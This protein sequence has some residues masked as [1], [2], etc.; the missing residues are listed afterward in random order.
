ME[1]ISAYNATYFKLKYKNKR[2]FIIPIRNNDIINNDIEIIN[3]KILGA[4]IIDDEIFNQL[5]TFIDENT[6]WDAATQKLL[7]DKCKSLKQIKFNFKPALYN[8]LKNMNKILVNFIINILY[9]NIQNMEHYYFLFEL[10]SYIVRL[11]YKRT[12]C[13]Y[14]KHLDSIQV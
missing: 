3:H 12:H 10:C 2:F 1:K 7:A 9:F 5:L 11:S 13:Y 8:I 4:E 14:Y 6:N